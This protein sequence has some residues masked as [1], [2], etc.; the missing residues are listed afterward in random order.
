ML[1]PL[2]V[3]GEVATAVMGAKRKADQVDAMRAA[4]HKGVDPAIA[5]LHSMRFQF[6]PD[7]DA[8]K[9]KF[10]RVAVE[11]QQRQ[12]IHNKR[13]RACITCSMPGS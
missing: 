7:C 11:S 6:C 8:A 12:V 2:R 4:A 13:A 1:V 5:I 3:S 10:A 9:V